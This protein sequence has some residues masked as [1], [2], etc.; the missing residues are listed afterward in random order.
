MAKKVALFGLGRMGRSHARELKEMGVLGCCV[1]TD[2][3]RQQITEELG[4]PFNDMTELEQCGVWDIVTPP[5]NHLPLVLSGCELGKEI[6]VEKPPLESTK[7]IE[8]ILHR[9]PGTK[10]GVNYLEMAHPVLGAICKQM[11]LLKLRPV[12][13]LHH[14]EKDHFLEGKGEGVKVVLNDLVHDLS[15]IDFIRSTVSEEPFST[16][17]PTV[18]SAFIQT[19]K[20]A[21]FSHPADARAGFLLRFSDG[22]GAWVQGSFIDLYHRQ[23]VVVTDQDTAFYGNTLERDFI[24]PAAA[25]IRGEENIQR[26]LSK[27]GH[28]QIRDEATQK[29]ALSET[30][31]RLLALETEGA[32]RMALRTM[33]GNF[34]E[35]DSMEDLICPLSRAYFYQKV[36]EDVYAKALA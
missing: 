25:L 27:T 7:D 2:P 35:A 5:P 19:Y 8:D 3:S 17:L 26:I 31:A 34:V 23:F 21:G 30:E 18:A 15:Q 32:S 6:F 11:K 28:C 12:Y 16:E 24:R 4:V 33:L 22:V 29:L 13:F 1:D 20:E 36:V 14:R 10:I 9:F